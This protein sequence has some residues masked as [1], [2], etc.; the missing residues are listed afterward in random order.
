MKKS[1]H[2]DRTALDLSARGAESRWWARLP[3]GLAAAAVALFVAAPLIPC[4][5]AVALG[6]HV[7]LVMAWFPVAIGCL[8]WQWRRPGFRL[9]WGRVEAALLLFLLIHSL[10]AWVMLRA[11]QPRSTLNA[12]WLWVAYGLLFFCVRQLF[13]SGRAQRAAISALIA[14][15]C[16]LATFGLY[17]VAYSNPQLRAKYARDLELELKRAELD[18]PAG[19]P[20]RVHIENRVAST[21]PISSFALTNSLAGYLTP[22]VLLLASILGTL[23]RTNSARGWSRPLGV[24]LLLLVLVGCLI[25]TKSR[26]AYAAVSLGIALLAISR[27][28]PRTWFRGSLLWGAAILLVV[29]I[30]AVARLGGLDREVI[31]EAPKSLQ[32]RVEYW[33]ATCAMIR[34]Y[35]WWGC[36]PG[37]FKAYYTRYKVPEASETIADPHNFLLEIAAT[38]GLPA[39]LLFLVAG[40]ALTAAMW[41]R[42]EASMKDR[43]VEAAEPM[44]SAQ[45]PS[46]SASSVYAGVGAGFLLAFPAGWAGG[47]P[48]DLALLWTAVPVTGVALWWLH[49]WV[50]HGH[51]A[52]WPLAVA[53]IALLVNLLAAGGIGFPGVGQLVWWLAALG[54]NAVGGP[55]GTTTAL[56][57]K[58]SGPWRPT[59]ALLILSGLAAACFLTM[60]RP[61][62]TAQQRLGEARRV[63]SESAAERLFLAAAAADPWWDEPWDAL[64]HLIAR[65]WIAAP[66]DRSLKTLFACHE[67]LLERNRHSSAAERY[68]GDRLL[69][70]YAASRRADLGKRAVEAY[71]RAIELYP[72]SALLHAQLAWTCHVTGDSRVAD[73]H[74]VKALRLD[75]LMPHAELKLARQRVVADHL[76]DSLPS[77]APTGTPWNAEQL[78]HYIRKSKYR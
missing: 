66:D 20:Q 39:L 75:A 8:V 31:T 47:I 1:A 4:E 50:L 28:V 23:P 33:R 21:E 56:A 48:P 62:L 30:A 24:G 65:R 74:A 64:A 42:H 43:A 5:S 51:L 16:G 15:A 9:P 14:V 49:A 58:R 45:V 7:V 10:S 78:M 35:P 63:H 53:G 37:N 73:R 17:Q 54:M 36:G 44:Q 40:A 67:E 2:R 72:N 60:Y 61:V 59:M 27:A 70:M 22:A 12:L 34:D 57:A 29:T 41:R 46:V 77:T 38:A 52:A 55:S 76:A 69:T 11:G 71:T 13:D 25:L 19:S 3:Q 6:T 68:C 32:Y 26:S 18:A